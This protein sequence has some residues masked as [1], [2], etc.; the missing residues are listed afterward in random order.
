MTRCGEQQRLS[1]GPAAHSV[2]GA[3]AFQEGCGAP[4]DAALHPFLHPA[5]AA[6]A[7]QPLLHPLTL[8]AHAATA[9]PR[10]PASASAATT[11]PLQ[12][13][14]LQMRGPISGVFRYPTIVIFCEVGPSLL[15]AC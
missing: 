10:H 9:S 12:G 6:T 2:N 11:L 8:P 15:T 4:C 5:S 1:C 3:W 13:G 14:G 7:T